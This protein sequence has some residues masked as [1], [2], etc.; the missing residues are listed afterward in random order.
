MEIPNSSNKNNYVSPELIALS[1]AGDSDAVGEIFAHY[2]KPLFRL[3]L[4][5]S[6]NRMD[7][8]DVVAETFANL[9]AEIQRTDDQTKQPERFNAWIFRRVRLK[10]IDFLSKE[11]RHRGTDSIEKGI[12]AANPL[13]TGVVDHNLNH[14][15]EAV[16]LDREGVNKIHR[17]IDRLPAVLRACM[18]RRVYGQQSCQEISEGLGIPLGTTKTRL[19]RGRAQIQARLAIH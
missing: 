15:P 8:E 16:A 19:N 3:A 17:S 13:I 18:Q 2:Q 6:G 7:A 5:L 11:K 4:Q 9:S 1:Q 10:L 12:E 14:Q